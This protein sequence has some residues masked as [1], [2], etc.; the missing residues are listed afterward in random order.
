MKKRALLW[1]TRDLRTQDNAMIV[2]PPRAKPGPMRGFGKRKGPFMARKNYAVEDII[3]HLRT[4]EIEVG[5]GMSV[6]DVCRKIGVPH[7]NYYRWKKEYGGMQVDQV[8]RLKDV[9]LENQ[10][11]RKLV[12]DLSIDNLILKEISSKNF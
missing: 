11:L 10:R 6:E 2:W 9:E 12:S 1:F 7:Q 5:R 3:K 8:K 4:I